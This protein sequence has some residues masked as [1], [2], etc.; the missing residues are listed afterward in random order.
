MTLSL[1]ER[2]E[3]RHQ[4][5]IKEVEQISGL[6]S[7]LKGALV[8]GIA[9]AATT[10]AAISMVPLIFSNISPDLAQHYQEIRDLQYAISNIIKA[11]AKMGVLTAILGAI[12]P[13]LYRVSDY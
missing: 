9:G 4:E 11:S 5:E 12:S 1:V 8:F 10:A 13:E 3:R 6:N 7:R 2:L